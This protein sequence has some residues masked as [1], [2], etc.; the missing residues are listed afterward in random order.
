MVVVFCPFPVRTR[1]ACNVTTANSGNTGSAKLQSPQ[2]RIEIT[3][4][5]HGDPAKATID[6][7]FFIAKRLD[8]RGANLIY[9]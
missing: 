8:D 9:F 7:D 5:N 3:T 1:Q 2:V 4:A 6:P